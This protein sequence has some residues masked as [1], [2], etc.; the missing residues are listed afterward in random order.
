MKVFGHYLTFPGSGSDQD[1][2][3]NGM[4]KLQ[5]AILSI[6]DLFADR[7]EEPFYDYLPLFTKLVWELLD[8]QKVPATIDSQLLRS[9]S[10]LRSLNIPRA[11]CSLK[12][13]RQTNY[14]SSKSSFPT[15]PF[16]ESDREKCDDD[17]AD[18][19]L[20]KS[21]GYHRRKAHDLSKES[22]PVF[23]RHYGGA[24][25]GN[26]WLCSSPTFSA[27]ITLSGPSRMSRLLCTIIATIYHRT[28]HSFP[29]PLDYDTNAALGICNLN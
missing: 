11:I 3:P 10:C 8:R 26:T 1:D 27:T 19:M 23:Q 12:I 9:N 2:S 13:R 16:R 18:F 28:R 20:T 17:L 5:S 6:L 15:W 25:A 14:F 24:C 4:D 7:D 21:G 22:L 29:G